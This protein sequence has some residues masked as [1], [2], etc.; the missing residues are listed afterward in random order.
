MPTNFSERV[1]EQKLNT[2]FEEIQF[3]KDDTAAFKEKLNELLP[4]TEINSPRPLSENSEFVRAGAVSDP[5]SFSQS[6]QKMVSDLLL[7]YSEI[8]LIDQS[9]QNAQAFLTNDIYE[10]SSLLLDRV[11]SQLNY[12]QNSV[13]ENN[14]GKRVEINNFDNPTARTTRLMA[15]NLFVD[16]NGNDMADL[17]ISRTLGLLTLPVDESPIYYT[18]GFP[19]IQLSESTISEVST[20]DN[21]IDISQLLNGQSWFSDTFVSESMIDGCQ[22]ALGIEFT[23]PHQINFI[24]LEPFSSGQIEV[25]DVKYLS[26][27][28]NMTSVDFISDLPVQLNRKRQ[29]IFNTITTSLLVIYLKTYKGERVEL[30]KQ[31]FPGLSSSKPTSFFYYPMGLSLLQVG[32][33]KYK[34]FGVYVG[35]P[36]KVEKLGSIKYI[37][38]RITPEDT[39]IQAAL[40]IE[41]Y[42]DE[43]KLLSSHKILIPSEDIINEIQSP[44]TNNVIKTQTP[45]DGDGALIIRLNGAALPTDGAEYSTGEVN[46]PTD[47]LYHQKDKLVVSYK[48]AYI[49]NPT[50]VPSDSS[51]KFKLAPD[52]TVLI[53]KR[54]LEQSYSYSKIYPI[55]FMGSFS[56]L[57]NITPAVDFYVLS[58]NQYSTT[59][60]NFTA[61][62]QKTIK[63]ESQNAIQ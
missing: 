1:L 18:D 43:N 33:Q 29:L 48:P 49:A 55:I 60:S 41:N 51:N 31:D 15:P 21:E 59:N 37:D 20:E 61:G 53:D 17:T 25:V 30:T 3:L 42:D 6:I 8:T 45:I 57:V 62:P 54:F 46:L 50:S 34:D 58:I 63:T 24:N 19:K 38:D 44:K 12:F 35:S 28:G 9:L 32:R 14:S 56:N 23:E 36:I 13:F 2:I 5:I 47:L 10:T 40:M 7:V 52:G 27:D 26:S 4:N 16:E 39:F 22:L 11:E